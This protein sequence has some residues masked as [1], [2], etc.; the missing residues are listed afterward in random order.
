MRGGVAPLLDHQVGRFD[1]RVARRH[2]R[3][4]AAG[5]AARDQPVAVALHQPDGVEG[6]PSFWCSTC[7]NGDQWPCP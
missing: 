1:D 5:A 2:Q 7:A 3:L 4:R 6:T